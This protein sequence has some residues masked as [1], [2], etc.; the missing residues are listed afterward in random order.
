MIRFVFLFFFSLSVSAADTSIDLVRVALPDFLRLV[1]SDVLKKSFVLD[2]SLVSDVDLFSVTLRNR[3]L[4]QLEK[5]AARVLA[6]RG[7]KVDEAG[8]VLYVSRLEK[9]P[10]DDVNK[11]LFVYRPEY[12]SVSYLMSLVETF[13]KPGSFAGRRQSNALGFNQLSGGVKS[14]M[15]SAAGVPVLGAVQPV[16][17][18]GSSD[19]GLNSQTTTEQ[20]L[21][22]FNGSAVD[23]QKLKSIFASVDLP[24][25]EL[26]IKAVVLEVQ[27]T[28]RDG[29]AV[30]F[31]A[32]V[33]KSGLGVGLNVAAGAADSGAGVVLSYKGGV[34]DFQ[35]VYSALS[36]DNRFK[37]LTSPRL[38]VKSD[39][40]A[41]FTVGDETPVLA[42]VSYDGNGKAI[43]NIE[44]KS[45]GVI[46]EVKPK[47]RDS[48]SELYVSQQISQFVPTT[49]GVNSSPTL[50][51]RELSTDVLVSDG[52][53][54]L[55]GGLD[56]EKTTGTNSGLSFFPSFLRAVVD[57]RLKTEIVLMLSVER[58]RAGVAGNI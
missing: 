19:I 41:R 52:D 46:F 57:E 8:G 42:S 1:Y 31:I 48:I 10:E 17:S 29:S 9:K 22:V 13:F 15:R 58:V 34:V 43:Q 56:Q 47:I 6:L 24:V 44:Y 2:A 35:A 11:E 21:I 26:L 23:V 14:G 55:L 3:S 27:R 16:Q 54:V 32:S 53:L 38:R 28:N 39:S 12:R 36:V 25:G 45:S 40:T 37:L 51:K 50:S 30:D 4:S 7:Y 5:E 20:D 18:M 49:N 33:L